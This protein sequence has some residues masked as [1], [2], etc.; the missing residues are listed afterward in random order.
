MVMFPGAPVRFEPEILKLWDGEFVPTTTFPKSESDPAV[1]VAGGGVEPQKTAAEEE[2]RGTGADTTSKSLLLLSVSWQPLVFLTDPCEL[3]NAAPLFT[4]A[5]PSALLAVPH[6]TRST[7]ME[8]GRVHG[9][10]VAPHPKEE[11]WLERTTLPDE[12]DI[13]K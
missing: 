3:V 9:V 13:V 5:P 10:A 8:C 1:I 12:A 11:A 6:A 2:L 4:L 7:I